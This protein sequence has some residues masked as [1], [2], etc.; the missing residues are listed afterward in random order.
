MTKLL[1]TIKA[2]EMEGF[3]IALVELANGQFCVAY[4]VGS[5]PVVSSYFVDYTAASYVFDKKIIE[6]NS[7]VSY[8]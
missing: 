3:A 6:Y 4:G 2:V 8:H 7:K 1:N 5:K